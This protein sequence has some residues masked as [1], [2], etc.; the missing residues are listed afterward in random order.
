M[1]LSS[2]IFFW[3]FCSISFYFQLLDYS[4][5]LKVRHDKLIHEPITLHNQFKYV[6]LLSAHGDFL[7]EKTDLLDFQSNK[8]IKKIIN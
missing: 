1:L 4:I 5:L 6:F 7:N 8:R 3:S 2:P